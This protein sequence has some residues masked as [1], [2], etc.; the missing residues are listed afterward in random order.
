[1]VRFC[2]LIAAKTETETV[3]VLN[4]FIGELQWVTLPWADFAAHSIF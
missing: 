4:L 1:M 3:A 2:L